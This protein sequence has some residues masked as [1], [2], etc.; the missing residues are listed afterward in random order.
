[1]ELSKLE[2]SN[3]LIA[4]AK[5]KYEQAIK[6]AIDPGLKY[7]AETYGEELGVITIIGW[8]PGFNDGE[9]CEH[10]T[11]HMY[12]YSD[13]QNYGME[14]LLEE[15]F[16]DDEEKVNKL[17]EQ[18]VKATDEVKMFV[19]TALDEYFEEKFGTNYRVHIL[20]ENNTYRIEEDEYDCGY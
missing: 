1:M 7:I 5:S 18:D 3:R 13:L 11:D 16:E 20:F 15:W 8:T 14:Y 6:D 12:G 19:A 10:S 17:L 4:E 2:E 9:P